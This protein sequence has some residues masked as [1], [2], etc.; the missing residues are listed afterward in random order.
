[1]IKKE[2]SDKMFCFLC[3]K[4]SRGMQGCMFVLYA[5]SEDPGQSTRMRRLIKAITG[6]LKVCWEVL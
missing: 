4:I 5:N 2:E 6:L 1:M 3:I